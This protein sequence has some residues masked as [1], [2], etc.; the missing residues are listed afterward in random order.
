MGSAMHSRTAKNLKL[1]LLAVLSG[2]ILLLANGNVCRRT[3]LQTRESVLKYDLATMRKAIDDYTVDNKQAPKSL[4]ALVGGLTGY[5]TSCL[6]SSV[7]RQY[8]QKAYPARPSLVV[9]P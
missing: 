6:Q 2:A 9:N 5:R 8:S 4:Q 7:S 1:L 3:P